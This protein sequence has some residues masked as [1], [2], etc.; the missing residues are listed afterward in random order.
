MAAKPQGKG[1]E[2]IS[3]DE[4][5]EQSNNS[6]SPSP[7]ASPTSPIWH[8]ALEQYYGELAKG[9]VRASVINKDLWNTQ[10]PEE[11]LAQIEALVPVQDIRSNAWAKTL[12]QLQPILLG[13]NDFV[14][15][16]A[17]GMGMNGKVAAVLWGSIRLIIKVCSNPCSRTIAACV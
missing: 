12:A 1:V 4:I 10:S 8:A 17:W 3:V 6:R 5:S 9:G 7:S 14:T 2:I 15:I 16:I 11:L 13:I